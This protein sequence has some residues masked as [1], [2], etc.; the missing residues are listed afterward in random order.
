MPYPRSCFDLFLTESIA[1]IVVNMSNL[2]GKRIYKDDWKEIT[3]TDTRAY[4]GLLILSGVYRSRNESTSSLWDAESG[5]TIFRATMSLQ[6]FH[7][8]TGDSL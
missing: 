1:T 4:M 6:K 2:E 5:R 3:Q 8:I 7:V